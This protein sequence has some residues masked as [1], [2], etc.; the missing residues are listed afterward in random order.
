MAEAAARAGGRI[1]RARGPEQV[2]HKG[3]VDLVTEVDLASEEAI[4]AFLAAA[5]PGVPVL[6][7]EAGGALT[8]STRWIVDPLDGTT[9][10]VHGYPSYGVSVALEQD[11]VLVA[12]CVYDP[13]HDVAFTATK[14]GGAWCEGR[15]LRVSATPD[16]DQSLLITG[17]P[18][19]RRQRAEHYLRFMRAF[20]ERSQGIRRAGAASIDFCHVAAGR[21]DGYWEFGLSPWDVAAGALLVEEAGGRVTDV[22]LGPLVV[23]R[24]R[25]L[26]TN[27]RIHEEMAAVIAPLLSSP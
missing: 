22:A 1:V 27:G 11:G 5:S 4:R 3:T 21:A 14:G 16:L 12:G 8:A 9:N 20:M 19:D 15:R 13:I 23:G 10:F 26:A 24:P 7:E 2:R 25:V 6:A 17:F 18:Y